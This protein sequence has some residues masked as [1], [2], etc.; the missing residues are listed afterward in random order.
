M[1]IQIPELYDCVQ[2]PTWTSQHPALVIVGGMVALIALVFIAYRAYTQYIASRKPYWQ[3]ALEDLS[4]L[5]LPI[6]SSLADEK[7]FYGGLTRVLKWYCCNRYGWFLASKTDIELIAV[8][9][10]LEVADELLDPLEQCMRT[11]IQVKF[12][13]DLVS[14]EQAMFD[15]RAVVSFIEQSI[16]THN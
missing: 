16:P 7:R 8:L 10:G 15:K 11:S 2:L 3:I 4:S 5:I 9:K 12:A 1:V 6:S 13:K 14:H